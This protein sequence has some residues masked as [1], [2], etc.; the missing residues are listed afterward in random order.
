MSILGSDNQQQV[1]ST[2]TGRIKTVIVILSYHYLY[3]NIY[4]LFHCTKQFLNGQVIVL[5]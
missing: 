1:D 4:K 2:R 3:K 5:V